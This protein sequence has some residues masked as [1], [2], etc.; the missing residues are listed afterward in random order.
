MNRGDS[1]TPREREVLAL[2]RDGLS[3]EEIAER[4]GISVSGAKYH[5]SEILSK[6]GLENRH[7][8]ARW[9]S[10]DERVPVVAPPGLR[11][12]FGRWLS[13]AITGALA[14][15]IASGAAL[16]VWALV[17]SRG[18]D[19]VGAT[20]TQTLTV[21]GAN[22][23]TRTTQNPRAIAAMHQD[24][25]GL[26]EPCRGQEPC[27]RNCPNDIGTMYEV[28]I[29]NSDGSVDLAAELDATGCPSA[30]IRLG[31]PLTNDHKLNEAA[32]EFARDA[33]IDAPIWTVI[34]QVLGLPVCG[35]D[36]PI[37]F[38]PRGDCVPFF[39]PEP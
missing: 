28:T 26:P 3:N 29:S 4:L 33:P 18:G 13:P 19:P 10:D 15:A 38:V 16:L 7:D 9:R 32:G 39:T 30:R 22:S 36:E 23:T 12:L 1:L 34:R 14:V 25:L 31:G 17:A 20:M 27:I 21:V 2:I 8:A 6:L 24:L 5:V 37:A 11:H 35:I